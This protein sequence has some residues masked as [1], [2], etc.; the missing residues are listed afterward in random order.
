[1]E[2]R[3]AAQLRLMSKHLLSVKISP[4][5]L[6][7]SPSESVRYGIDLRFTIDYWLLVIGEW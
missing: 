3:G 1:M 4:V 5:L 7:I 2:N 6:F